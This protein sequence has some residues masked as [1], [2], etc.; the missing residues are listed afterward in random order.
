M[1]S[2]VKIQSFVEQMAEKGH[3]LDTDQLEEAL[4]E[5]C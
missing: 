5:Y 3:D 2:Y 4:A 1:A